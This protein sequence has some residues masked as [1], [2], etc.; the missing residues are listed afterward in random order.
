MG[1]TEEEEDEKVVVMNQNI[2]IDFIRRAQEARPAD[3]AL[4]GDIRYLW[5]ALSEVRQLTKEHMEVLDC[6]AWGD[7]IFASLM[8]TRM[9]PCEAHYLYVRTKHDEARKFR[10]ESSADCVTVP[11][12]DGKI[13]QCNPYDV[14][15]IDP[16]KQYQTRA[17][18]ILRNVLAWNMWRFSRVFVRNGDTAAFIT[19][20]QS[21]SKTMKWERIPHTSIVHGCMSEACRE[22]V[23]KPQS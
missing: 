17:V 19:V 3:A 22:S 16:V 21:M 14:I 9:M 18:R 1:N 11:I 10:K 20:Y 2:S 15:I 13:P 5:W 4:Q 7:G 23:M 6:S 8:A 12:L